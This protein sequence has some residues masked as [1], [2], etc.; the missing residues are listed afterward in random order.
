MSRTI[1]VIPVST[2]VGLSSVTLGLINALEQKGS[3]TA[4]MKPISQP[5]SGE[6]KVDR[7]TSILRASTALDTAEPIM[8]SEAETLIGQNQTD[9]LL[10]RIIEKYNALISDNDLVVV[11]GLIPTRQHSMQQV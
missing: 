5:N 9:V 10:E 3:K 4:F 11:E 2:S 8:L 6:D 1:I 7:S